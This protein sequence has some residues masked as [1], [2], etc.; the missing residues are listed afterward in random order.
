MTREPKQLQ[1][2]I[3]FNALALSPETATRDEPLS[4]GQNLLYYWHAVLKRKWSILSIAFIAAIIAAF[5]SYSKQPIYKATA[6][7]LLDPYTATAMSPLKNS[8]DGSSVY[9]QNLYYFN[10]QKAIISSDAFLSYTADRLSLTKNELTPSTESTKLWRN[11]MP[12]Q[13]KD[14]LQAFS[15]PAEPVQSAPDDPEL[16]KQQVIASLS[17][18]NM[19]LQ[20]G[21]HVVSLSYQSADPAIAARITNEIAQAYIDYGMETRLENYRNATSWLTERT[22]DLRQD[23]QESESQLQQYRENAELVNIEGGRDVVESQLQNTFERL[24]SAQS[25]LSEIKTIYDEIEAIKA[26]PM[27]V[28]S[29]HPVVLQNEAVKA[30]YTATTTAQLGVNDLSS[31]NGPKHPQMREA[32]DTLSLAQ[33]SLAKEVNIYLNNISKEYELAQRRVSSLKQEFES[34]KDQSKE[35]NRKYFTVNNLKQEVDIN[36]ELYDLFVQKFKETDIGSEINSPTARVINPA[37]VPSAPVWPNP[38]RDIAKAFL[39]ALV[40]G[41]ALALLLEFMDNTV[42]SQ[43]QMEEKLG[44][45]H[46]VSLPLLTGKHDVPEQYFLTETGSAFAEA[47]R[48]LR[49]AV[50]LSS[51]DDPHRIV[52]LTSTVPSEGKTTVAINLAVAGGSGMPACAPTTAP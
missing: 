42:R 14:F 16:I 23:L 27:S 36:R 47:T 4:E 29:K 35:L 8:L 26:E 52:A 18:I 11:L 37:R 1:A 33:A 6:Y 44:V 50:L 48:T 13:I 45:T 2:D 15:A 5:N 10:N 34:L 49:T 32:K 25:Q 9:Y 41:I 51:L 22:Q 31:R 39:I 46:L 19:E 43:Q 40:A 24:I 7:L 38:P 17:G 20:E 3:P 28:A 21:S 30:A 12:Q